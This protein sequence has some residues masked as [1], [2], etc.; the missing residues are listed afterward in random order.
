M[1]DPVSLVYAIGTF[2]ALFLVM[3]KVAEMVRQDYQDTI[4]RIRQEL[5]DLNARTTR[6]TMECEDDDD[7]TVC[8]VALERCAELLGSVRS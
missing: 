5:R 8:D 2:G 1:Q 3:S 7:T 6:R 4:A